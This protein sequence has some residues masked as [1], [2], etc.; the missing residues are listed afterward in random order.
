MSRLIQL[1]GLWYFRAKVNGSQVTWSTGEKNK[2]KAE[3]KL[4]E[5]EGRARFAREQSS[6]ISQGKLPT[7]AAAIEAEVRRLETDVSKA[8]SARVDQAFGNFL[9]WLG[10]KHP[11]LDK[12]DT[13]LLENYQRAR[14]KMKGKKKCGA[15]TVKHE[16]CYITRML[17]NNKLIVA[18]P[19]AIPG[20]KTKVRTFTQEEQDKFINACEPEYKALFMTANAV[21]AR[22]AE[23]VPTLR[24]GDIKSKHTPLLKSEVDLKNLRIIIR[25]SKV[26]EG[27]EVKVRSV[28][29]DKPLAELLRQQMA[30][31]P[32]PHVFKPCWSLCQQFDRI[33]KKAGI[34]KYD[35]LGR[36]LVAHSF[37]HTFATRNRKQVRDVFELMEALGHTQLTTTQGYLEVEVPEDLKMDNSRFFPPDASASINYEI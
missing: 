8:Q 29:I 14:L 17:R 34:P 31:T 24:K 18:K 26:R 37:R 21:G 33:L 13:E 20:G 28:P 12:I 16:L 36:K 5:L 35:H 25:P 4:P 9:E 19:A 1:R 2:R 27:Q 23:L 30:D 15:E 11:A 22:P 7:L 10:D 3:A 32:G 6:S